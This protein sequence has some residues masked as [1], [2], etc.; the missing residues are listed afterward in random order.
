MSL[1][2]ELKRRNVFRVGIAYLVVSWLVLQVADV[3]IDNIGAPDWLFS[4][5]LLVLGIGFPVVLVFAWAFELTPDGLKRESE[6]DRSQSIAP[7]TGKKLNNAILALM[8]LAIAYL[9]FDKFSGNRPDSVSTPAAEVAQAMQPET[10]PAPDSAPEI[11]RQSI[12]VLPFDNRSPREEDEYFAEGIHDDLLTTLSRIGALKVISRTSVLRYKD[13]ELPI[14][15]IAKELG[16]ATVMEGAVQRSG[17]QVRINVQLIDAQ[18]DEHL[19]AE[20]FDREL[21]A[22]NLFAIQSEIS[23]AIAGALKATL[24]PEEER[25]VNT[26]PT[27]NLAAY[28][29]FLRG[30]QLMTTRNSEKLEQAIRE[31]KTAVTLDPQFA[32]A[33]VGLADSNALLSDYGSLSQT[34]ARE[35]QKEA[36]LRALDIDPNLGEA[37]ASMGGVY[38]S[39]GQHSESDAAYKKAIELNPN[40]ASAYQWY[41]LRLSQNPR[42]IEE[43]LEMIR[44]AA[45]LDPGSPIIQLNLGM[46]YLNKG[47]GD[48]A[49]RHLEHLTELYPDFSR[50]YLARAYI[51]AVFKGR[52]DEA[53]KLI[54]QSQA[55]DPGSLLTQS[56]E[57]WF[58]RQL[59]DA[60]SV[61]RVLERMQEINPD[62][63]DT[64]N[65]ALDLSFYFGSDAAAREALDWATPRL[66]H[67]PRFDSDLGHRRLMLGDMAG[68]REAYLQAEPRWLQPEAWE[69]LLNRKYQDACIVGWVFERTN[70]PVL[71]GR[72]RSEAT[73]YY[74]EYLPGLVDHLDASLPE[75]CH[76]ANG[77]TERAL[78]SLAT[79]LEHG[80]LTD[81]GHWH[82]LPL[83]DP[84]RED[85]R[86]QAM[87]QQRS[88]VLSG[89]RERVALMAQES[90]S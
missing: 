88:E 78:D 63:P 26:L 86:Y 77:D 4:S 66:A 11:K 48:A 76:L 36:A 51:Q 90:G 57:A 55:K 60:Q 43:Q 49:A 21:T 89:Q 68:A 40:Y 13:T 12:A 17:N 20:I 5:I 81:W 41:A 64:I 73:R 18:T 22:E 62:H 67:L 9:L 1:F 85:P 28:D 79:Q 35:K 14:P 69:E 23:E 58:F 31:F 42:R 8:A 10:E 56:A 47:E 70:D 65:T 87:L 6:V 44:K 71:G 83:F 25:R 80:H 37:Y 84:I 52:L 46:A 32:L 19:W 45:E 38:Y 3:M 72:L 16:V 15:D 34:E 30:R 39:L 24:S 74:I 27:Q 7:Q 33:W 75:L 50:T 59:G 82:R 54:W 2:A 53:I 61:E 29:A